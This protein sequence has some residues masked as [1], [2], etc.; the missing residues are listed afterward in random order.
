VSIGDFPHALTKL[1]SIWQGNRSTTNM[2]HDLSHKGVVLDD[3]QT[4]EVD[5]QPEMNNEHRLVNFLQVI[6]TGVLRCIV[7]IA[8][9]SV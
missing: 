8:N 2:S 4:L 7:S 3:Y 5:K 6:N 9:G 1:S